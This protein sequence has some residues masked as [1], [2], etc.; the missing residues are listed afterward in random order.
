MQGFGFF[1]IVI[2]LLG[3]AVITL[4]LGQVQV[5]SD[6]TLAVIVLAYILAMLTA[7]MGAVLYGLGGVVE[8]IRK[9]KQA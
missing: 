4:L 7:V 1:F 2:G 3:I 9:S 8:A 6:I 5:R